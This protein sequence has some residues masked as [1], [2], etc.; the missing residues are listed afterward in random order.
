[1][2]MY[3]T[4]SF[5]LETNATMV[6]GENKINKLGR[7]CV[8]IVSIQ[9]PVL[10]CRTLVSDINKLKIMQKSADTVSIIEIAQEWSV[11]KKKKNFLK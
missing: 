10:Y 9:I 6:R 11:I 2:F 8:F 4:D 3:S 1:M 7:D 5:L